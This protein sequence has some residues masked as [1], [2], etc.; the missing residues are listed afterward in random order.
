MK[1][2]ELHKDH[3][4]RMRARFKKNGIFALE[5]HEIL[6]MLLFSALPRRNTNPI[7]HDLLD[8]FGS[9]HGVLSA[10][11]NE[12]CSVNG[13]GDTSAEKLMFLG[14]MFCGMLP[15]LFEN[16]PLDSEDKIGMYAVMQMGISPAGSAAAVYLDKDGV[17]LGTEWL[18]L[19]KCRMTEEI[20]LSMGEAAL[21]YGAVSVVLMHNH[22]GE[23]LEVSPEDA[24]ITKSLKDTMKS[25][26]FDKVWHVITSDEGYIF[27]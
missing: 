9:I 13:I 1:S 26:E 10:T 5:D 27:I 22:K 4:Q 15:K 18:Y 23:P 17:I 20:P 6:E 3:R 12:L 14:E 7:A 21:R 8:R 2:P 11:K 16:I 25:R 19:G 24:V